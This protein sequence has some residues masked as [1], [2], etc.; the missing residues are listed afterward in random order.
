MNEIIIAFLII[1]LAFA[2][3]SIGLILRNQPIKG[4]CGGMANLQDGS[5]CEI[6]G[7]TDPNSCS[8]S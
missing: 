3:L 5:A 6:C 1:G 7:T 2:G 8:K 4:S